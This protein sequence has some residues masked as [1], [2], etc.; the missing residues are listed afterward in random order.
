[1][2]IKMQTNFAHTRHTRTH[3]HTQVLFVQA[4]GTQFVTFEI[5]RQTE[6]EPN[7]EQAKQNEI[8]LHFYL[9]MLCTLAQRECVANLNVPP[10][11][12]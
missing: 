9:Q 8:K 11:C 6:R 5:R 3:T 12:V 10:V 4:G 7:A 2:L 1:M